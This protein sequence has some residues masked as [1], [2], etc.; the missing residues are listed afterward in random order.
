MKP[1][2]PVLLLL[3]L[4]A[5]AQINPGDPAVQALDAQALHLQKTQ[6]EWPNTQW[7]QRYQDPQLNAL[8][9]RAL[10]GNPSL[11]SAQARVRMANAAVRGARAVQWPQINAQYHMTRQ[12]YSE[13]YIYPP[14]LGGS[15]NT[16]N[17]LQL[18]AS[19]DLDLWGKNRSLHAAAQ[20]RALAA[21]AEQ[22]Q[23]RNTLIAATTQSY[24]QLQ[25]ALAQAAAIESIVGKLRE[26]LSITRDRFNNGLGT[27]VDVDQADSAVSSA[28]VQLSQARNNAQLLR[29]QIATLIAVG[30]NQAPDIAL[31]PGGPLPDGVPDTLPMDLLGRRPDIVAARQQALAA[32]SEVSAAKADFFPNVNLSAFVGFMSLGMD[33]LIRDSSQNYG[34][35]PAISL[36]ILHGGALNAQLE[37]RRGARDLAIAQYNQTILAA[38]REVADTNASIRSLR[39][40]LQDQESS[41][42][43]ISSAYD[44]ALKRYKAGLGNFVQVLL[45]QSEVLKQAVQTTDLHARAYMLDAQLATALG[46]G[47][48]TPQSPTEH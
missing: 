34:A 33:K 19:L 8:I 16:D 39:Q 23:A 14:S 1:F 44:I 2:I 5:C 7:W 43:A 13:N 10:A 41:M 47:Y 48:R 12:L 46:G 26:A 6:I 11:D 31:R 40:Q 32:G 27:Q 25:G 9:G 42:A 3:T 35:G 4:S 18:Q 21:A 24:F 28:Q 17:S 37:E 38:V 29:H 36:P 15:I 30:P 20:S 22:Q 45:A